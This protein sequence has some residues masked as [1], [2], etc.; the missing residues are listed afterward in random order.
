[1]RS[2]T[3]DLY[4]ATFA[5][6]VVVDGLAADAVAGRR[7]ACAACAACATLAALMALAVALILAAFARAS[8][9]LTASG[10]MIC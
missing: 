2:A 9:S 8:A 7:P 4:A 5:S 1:M 6:V 10:I 3:V